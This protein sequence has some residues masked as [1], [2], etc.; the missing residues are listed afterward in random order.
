MPATCSRASTRLVTGLSAGEETTYEGPLAAGDHAGETAL[1]HGQRDRR[2]GAPASRRRRRLRP[3][4]L[5]V[6][7]DRRAARGPA[8]AGRPHQDQQPGRWRPARSCSRSS[9]RRTDFELPK[10]GHRARGARATS[11]TRTAS[12]T[13]STAPR[14]PRRPSKALRVQILLDQLADDFDIEVEQSE[15][16]DYLLNASRQYNIGP[17]RSSSSQVREGGPDP[18]DGRRGCALQGHRLRAASRHRQGRRRQ[19]GRPVRRH[20]LG[21]G[22]DRRS[23]KRSTPRTESRERER[24]PTLWRRPSLR[25]RVVSW[26]HWT[27]RRQ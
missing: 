26:S 2:Q 14:S 23:R 15:L 20:R 1:D 24:G 21:R 13:T 22:R 8:R 18:L 12:R 27:A 16:L 3:A 17:R 9:P 19:E 7:H 25:S 6:R 5:R 4:R 10:Q 11:R